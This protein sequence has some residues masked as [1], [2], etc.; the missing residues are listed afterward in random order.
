[1]YS[2]ILLPLYGYEKL[3]IHFYICPQNFVKMENIIEDVV[4]WRGMTA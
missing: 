3:S 4:G 2:I 1:M